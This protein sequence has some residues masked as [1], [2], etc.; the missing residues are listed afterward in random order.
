MPDCGH[1]GLLSKRKTWA[2]KAAQLEQGCK[3]LQIMVAGL[4]GSVGTRCSGLLPEVVGKRVRESTSRPLSWNLGEILG[5]F[6]GHIHGSEFW[7]Y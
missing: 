3:D 6:H 1:H 4:L 7:T 5:L 2:G